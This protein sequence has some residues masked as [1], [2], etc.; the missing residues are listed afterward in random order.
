VVAHL[1]AGNLITP[2]VAA[3]TNVYLA[4]SPEVAGITGKYFYRKKMVPPPAA[5]RDKLL[6]GRL[7]QVSCELTGVDALTL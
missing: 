6:A 7:W 2:T 5:A 1:K 3:E 4:T